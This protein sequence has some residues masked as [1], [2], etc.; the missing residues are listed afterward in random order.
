MKFI[1][2]YFGFQS[3]ALIDVRSKSFCAQKKPS[4][5]KALCLDLA[6]K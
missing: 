5:G 6:L 2:I 1:S 4:F 3:R